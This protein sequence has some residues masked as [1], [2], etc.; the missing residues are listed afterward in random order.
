MTEPICSSG[1]IWSGRYGRT[2]LLPGSLKGNSTAQMPPVAVS[3]AK[4]TLQYRRR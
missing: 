1:E 3:M 4:W 2:E